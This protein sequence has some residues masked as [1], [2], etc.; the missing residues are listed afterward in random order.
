MKYTYRCFSLAFKILALNQ[1]LNAQAPVIHSV[2]PEAIQVDQ[3]GKFEVKLDLTATYANPY[4]YDNI[5]VQA[6][7][8]GPDNVQETVDGFFMQ[9]YS[10]TNQQTGAIAPVG[11]GVF[12]V[13]FSPDKP[14]V[15]TYTLSCIN[16]SGTAGW[17]AQTFEC[18]P[19]GAGNQG[20]VRNHQTNFLHFDDGSQYIPVG[21]NMAWHTSNP[22]VDYTNWVTKLSTYGG[23]FLRLWMCHWGLGLEWRNNGYEGLKKYRQNNAFYLDWLFDFC[24][25]NGVYVQFCLN[26]H[27]QVSSQVN[28]NWDESP[29]NAVNGGPCQNTWDFFTSQTA[30]SAIKNRL[31]YTVARWGYQRSIMAWE[32]FNEVNWTDEFEQHRTEITAWHT[33]MAAYLKQID[34]RQHLVST[35]YAEDQYEAAVWNLPDI[36]FTQTHYYLATPNIE[37][38]LAG[39]NQSYLD[40]YAKP[41]LNGEFGLG[42]SATGLATL[43]PSGIHVH[44]CLWG[45]LFSGGMGS[46]MQWWWDTYA[47]ERNLYTHYTGLSAVAGEIDL[48]QDDFRPVQTQ[49]LGAPDN[50]SLTPSSGWGI[51]ADA[52]FTI[53][54]GGSVS[55]AGAQLGI[56]LYGASWNTEFRSPPVFHVNYPVA[57][58]F[59]VKTS[60]A[61][62][63]MPRITI[64]LDGVQL[65]DQSAGVNQTFSINVPAGQHTI[66]VDNTGTDWITI[67]SYEFSGLGQALDAYLLKSYD[68]RKLAGWVLNHRYNHVYVKDNGAPAAVQGASLSLNGLKNGSYKI[69][70]FNCLTGSV[71]ST[72]T[73]EVQDGNAVI[74]VPA[75]TWD[76]AFLLDGNTTGTAQPFKQ[77]VAFD[78]F[79]NPALGGE[80]R[81]QFEAPAGSHTRIHLMDAAGKPVRE[82]FEGQLPSGAQDLALPLGENLPAG[83]YWISVETGGRSG[84]KAV[85]VVR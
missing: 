48:H 2:T 14:G 43:D 54:P 52:S 69:N 9:D 79:P 8:T 28:P 11:T 31:R 63:T 50:L 35:S 24:A 57:G 1:I 20:F 77:A 64:W 23:N 81:V 10:I 37:R 4:D 6:V 34:V 17:P 72:Q 53:G 33:E 49:V 60:S 56:Y 61:A 32:L 39:G 5:R 68:N 36:D 78:V 58:Q 59:K 18:L 13:R 15:W 27:G 84:A 67:A 29:Y 76:L 55:P 44:N 21:E 12:K 74:P 80:T 85:S 30:R 65:L 3:F 75:V 7:F 22:I 83:I 16:A 82:L 62:G 42:G 19:P 45:G 47:D 66:K 38:V 40:Q 26:H 46:G 73:V 71:E 51:I 41:T 25:G 70:W